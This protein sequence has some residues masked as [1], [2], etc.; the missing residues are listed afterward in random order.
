MALK[1]VGGDKAVATEE[2]KLQKGNPNDRDFTGVL[3][4]S[5]AEGFGT[6]A[7]LNVAGS[8]FSQASNGGIGGIIGTGLVLAGVTAV[9]IGAVNHGGITLASND[10]ISPTPPPTPPAAKNG[11]AK[12]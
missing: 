12:S 5:A 1:T 4:D 8:V 10:A 3:L 6:S 9:T 2:A 11:L 7:A